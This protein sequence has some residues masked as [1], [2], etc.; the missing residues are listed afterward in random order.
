MRSKP[1]P[2]SFGI[3]ELEPSDSPGG[4]IH[5][6]ASIPVAGAAVGRSPR[7]APAW[8]HQLPWWMRPSTRLPSTKASRLVRGPGPEG[9]S[10]PP[11]PLREVSI[12]M[13]MPE[14][15]PCRTSSVRKAWA[16]PWLST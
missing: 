9:R 2:S 11:Q 14:S 16:K 15:K 12:S 10:E 1:L 8:L 7:P 3:S 13:P 5:T 6:Y 4:F